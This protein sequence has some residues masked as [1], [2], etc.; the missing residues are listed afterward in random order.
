MS[1][2]S[3]TPDILTFINLILALAAFGTTLVIAIRRKSLRVVFSL[4]SASCLYMVGLYSYL[5]FTDPDISISTAAFG[6]V[7]AIL[8]LAGIIMLALMVDRWFHVD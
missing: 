1:N 3:I 4:I 6:R 5:L 2:D 8:M 7:G